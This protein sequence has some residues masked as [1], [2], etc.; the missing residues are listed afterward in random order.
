MENLQLVMGDITSANVDAIVNAA[1]SVMLGGGGV[2]GAIHLAAGPALLQACYGVPEIDGIRCPAGEAR[3]TVAGDLAAQ[4]VIHTVGPRYHIDPQPEVLLESA[5]RSVLH[6]ALQHNCHSIALPA[7]SCGVYAYPL[8]EAA[9]IAL[10]VCR[11]SEFKNLQ[12]T[13]Y[14]F[15]QNIFDVFSAA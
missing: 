10:G 9:H 8:Q 7:I 5:Y 4:Y 2:D 14:L 1:N 3:M 6:L 11:E 15:G 13:F 12:M